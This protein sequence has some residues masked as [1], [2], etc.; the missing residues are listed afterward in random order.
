MQSPSS[1]TDLAGLS[2]WN[3]T[4]AEQQPDWREHAAYGDTCQRLAAAPPLVSADEIRRLHW[5]LSNLVADG[6]LVLQLGDCA[7]S[8]YECTTSHIA[9]K[10]DVIESL[11]DRLS[12][13]TGRDVICVGRMAG[14]FAKPRSQAMERHGNICIPSFRGHMINSEIATPLARKAN[15]RRMFWAYDAS[16]KVQRAMRA[17]RQGGSHL[18]AVEGPWSS[19]EA[20]VIDYETRMIRRDFGTGGTYLTST[21]L[22]WVGERTRSPGSAHVALLASVANPVA[23]KVGPT[24]TPDEVLAVC[25]ALDPRREPGRL[26]LIPRM[27]RDRIREVLPPIVRQ[28]VNAGH[29]AIW[30]SDPMHGNTVVARSVGLKTRYLADIITEALRFRDIIEK[31]RLHAAG[32]HLEVSARDVSECIGGAVECEDD[33]QRHY[34]SLCDPRLNTDQA[35]ELIEAWVKGVAR[36]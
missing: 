2:Q 34:S 1:A 22:P 21:H 16:D 33:L 19:H 7:E 26:V 11:G 25:E 9:E 4:P 30:L 15:P 27:G 8:F 29:P 13:L 6:N 18:P 17:R 10:M 35:A 3:G 14:Q 31:N 23:C 24:A 20:L 12:V 32:L 36:R 5:S 28:V